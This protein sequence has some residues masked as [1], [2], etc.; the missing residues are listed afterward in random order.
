MKFYLIAT[1]YIT[2][3]TNMKSKYMAPCFQVL[4]EVKKNNVYV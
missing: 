3:I 1:V 4:T 2:L